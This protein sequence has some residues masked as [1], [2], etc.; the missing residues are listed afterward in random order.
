MHPNQIAVQLYTLRDLTAEDLPG[1]LHAVAGAGY[2]AVELAGL[3][4]IE[5][6]AL[7]DL[8]AA[9]DLAPIAAH[10]SLD[11]LRTDLVGLLD[12]MTFL[13]CPRIIVPWLPEADRATPAGVRQVAAELGEFARV[14]AGRGIA[15]G[16][17]NHAFE[18]EPLD[19]TTVW[20]VLLEELPRAVELEIDVYWVG[21]GGRDPVDVIRAAGERARLLHMKDMAP[22]PDRRDVTPGDGIL[23]WSDI[24]AAATEVGVEWYVVEEDNPRDAIA[25]IARGR[26][27]LSD[28]GDRH[29]GR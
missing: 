27:F 15:L 26:N 13:G 4:P 25:E 22:G 17:H 5:A 3:P 8:L 20:D 14:C 1:T 16:Y 28:L 21:V 11:R 29:L 18:F 10:E 6:E 7:R 12:R 9:E 24:V 23:P 19:G 2:R